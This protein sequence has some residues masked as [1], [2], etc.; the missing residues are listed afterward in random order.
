LRH[1]VGHEN[2]VLFRAD[3]EIQPSDR[4]R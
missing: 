4:K 2:G 3:T 1:V